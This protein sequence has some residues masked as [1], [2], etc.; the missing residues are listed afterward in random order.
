[1]KA[2]PLEI[3]NALDDVKARLG[4]ETDDLLDAVAA[5]LVEDAILARMEAG[6]VV[7]RP[8]LARTY[9]ERADALEKLATTIA[10]RAKSA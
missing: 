3:R 9:V 5:M 6:A 2:A 10:N 7:G 8:G 1:M 4:V